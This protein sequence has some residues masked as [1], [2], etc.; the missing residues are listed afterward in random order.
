MVLYLHA[1]PLPPVFEIDKQ[2]AL[3]TGR[4]EG[5]AEADSIISI[6]QEANI[7]YQTPRFQTLTHLI[8]IAYSLHN[9]SIPDLA[10]HTKK[11][12]SRHQFKSH[13]LRLYYLALGTGREAADQFRAAVDQ[14]YFLRNIKAMDSVLTG[15]DIVGAAAVVNDEV[16]I[17][18]ANPVLLV[19]Y[20]HRLAAGGSFLPAQSNTP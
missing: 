4:H 3:L 20:G 16:R 13:P 7:F 18:R 14:K 9:T 15:G 19:L 6:T 8:Q 17:E 10:A 11:L 12:A 5:T 1:G 2:F